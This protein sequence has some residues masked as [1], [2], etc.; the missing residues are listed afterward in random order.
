MVEINTYILLLS[1]YDSLHGGHINRNLQRLTFM[2][3][4]L[5]NKIGLKGNFEIRFDNLYTVLT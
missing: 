1:A 4:C 3:N 2:N 5:S